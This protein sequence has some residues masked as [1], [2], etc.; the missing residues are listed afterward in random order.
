MVAAR[1]ARAGMQSDRLACVSIRLRTGFTSLAGAPRER[2]SEVTKVFNVSRPTVYR[3]VKSGDLESYTI[4]GSVRVPA[5]ATD[6][7]W[8]AALPK[9]YVEA[10]KRIKPTPATTG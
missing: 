2:V 5:E 8:D 1:G 9:A 3:M 6:A 10:R 4:A 7:Q